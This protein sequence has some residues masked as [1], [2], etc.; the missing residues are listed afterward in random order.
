[1]Q[2]LTSLSNRLK[3]NRLASTVIDSLWQANCP[4][5]KRSTD[6]ILC[7]DC[8]RQISACQSPEFLQADYPISPDLPLYSWGIYDGALK[9]AIAAC[10]YG[11][12]PAIMEAIAEK[13]ATTWKRSPHAK[14]LIQNHKKLS[15]IPIPLHANKLKSRGF[16][17]AEILA[18]R[19]C[20]LSA[21]PCHPQLLQRVKDTKAQMQT[22]SITERNQN[23]SHAFAV[24][25]PHR[26]PQTNPRSVILVDDIYTTG[27]TIH[28]AIATLAHSNLIVRAVVVISRPQFKK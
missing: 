28:E 16:N 23:L 6:G 1:M 24:P 26:S 4:L 27:A 10:K 11:N 22:K 15:V 2:W 17:Q 8:D 3:I 5:C 21:L 19:F 14:A 13:I 12:H 7:K 9:R 25:L 20:D 18:Q